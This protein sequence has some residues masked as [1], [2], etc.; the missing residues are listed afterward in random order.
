MCDTH[1][2]VAA[3]EYRAPRDRNNLDTYFWFCLDHVRE[4]NKAWNYYADMSED[5]IEQHIRDDVTWRRPSWPL[6]ARSAHYNRAAAARP[7]V[8]YSAFA[9]EDWAEHP[10][11]DGKPG[12]GRRPRPGS[13]ED[14]ALAILNLDPPVTQDDIKAR[15]KNLVKRHHPDANGGDKDAEE[16]LKTINQAYSTLKNGMNW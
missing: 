2:C 14:K 9:P 8:D 16:R 6:G 4:Y 15:Y 1:D 12:L 10:A 7:H 3:A 5:E 11:R 13:P